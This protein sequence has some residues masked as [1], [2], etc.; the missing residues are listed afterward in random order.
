[1][2]GLVVLGVA[3]VALGL[4]VFTLTGNGNGAGP[5]AQGRPPA[6]GTR[7]VPPST[8][9]PRPT[10]THGRPTTTPY[11][12]GRT[13]T[14]APPPTSTTAAPLE[15]TVAV[16]VY[17]NSTV[18]DLAASAANDIRSAGFDVVQVGNYPGGVIGHSTVYYS[19]VPGEQ[20]IANEIGKAFNLRVL[21][22]FPGIAF[23]SPGVIVIV[24]QD[25]RVGAK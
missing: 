8:T 15:Q 12:S 7:T 25:F 9:A 24:T 20:Q 10:T 16:R 17:N 4:G 3:V 1:L 22:R 13:T 6:T 11:P 18:K 2:A 23:A 19:P 21:P 5:R 14:V